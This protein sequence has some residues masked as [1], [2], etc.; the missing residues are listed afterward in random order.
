M[1]FEELNSRISN[2]KP[3]TE[4]V[5]YCINAVINAALK[6]PLQVAAV[7]RAILK[8]WDSKHRGLVK[9]AAYLPRNT[10]PE[11]MHMPKKLGG[12]GLQSLEHE[13]DILRVQTQMRLLNADSKAGAVVRAAKR[14]A[15]SGRERKTVQHHTQEALQRWDMYITELEEYEC[16]QEAGITHQRR[17]DRATAKRN[18][19][20][21]GVVHAFGDG[22]TWQKE[23]IT[24]W[25][26]HIVGDRLSLSAT[27]GD[28]ASKTS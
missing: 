16:V 24:G 1:K 15:D 11:L 7:P 21:T 20:E 22:A 28:R 3:T 6:F 25:G 13:I 4:M 12:K 27:Q 14:R 9:K 23:G 2:T 10:S 17:T 26:M 8:G 19:K 5:V 18:K